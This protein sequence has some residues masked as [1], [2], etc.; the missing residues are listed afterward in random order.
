MPISFSQC[1][2]LTGISYLH[3]SKS[4]YFLIFHF[5][6]IYRNIV[7]QVYCRFVFYIICYTMLD[8]IKISVHWILSPLQNS[9]YNTIYNLL[10]YMCTE[11][12]TVYTRLDHSVHTKPSA[13]ASVPQENP[14]L[15]FWFQA[16]I[17]KLIFTN[18][19]SIL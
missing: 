11:S 8:S 10:E 13:S 1:L 7:V 3:A 2:I 17:L 9:M 19:Y 15:L 12:M 6:T 5:V 18:G 14:L 4:I 16:R